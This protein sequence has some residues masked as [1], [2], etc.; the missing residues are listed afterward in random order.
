MMAI[1]SSNKKN[2]ITVFSFKPFNFNFINQTFLASSG[3]LPSPRAGFSFEFEIEA[4]INFPVTIL[5]AQK[6]TTIKFL[7]DKIIFFLRSIKRLRICKIANHAI[8]T[9]RKLSLLLP[10]KR[11]F[12][13][14]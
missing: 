2:K 10:N 6:S 14:F 11:T 3:L 4:G 1:L 9:L 13:H 7:N 8:V 12:Y 5:T